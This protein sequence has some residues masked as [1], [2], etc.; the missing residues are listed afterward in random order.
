VQI[1]NA[2]AIAIEP[3]NFYDVVA[4]SSENEDVAGERLL[5]EYG[6]DPRAQT[7]ETSPHA[8]HA[9]RKSDPRSGA[10]LDHLR[11]LSRIER[12]SP[13]SAPLSTLIIARLGNSMWIEPNPAGCRWTTGSRISTSPGIATVTG[14]KAVVGATGPAN[15][16]L[17]KA[18]RH[19]NTWLAFTLFAG[20]TTNATLAPSSSVSST[21]RGFSATERNRRTRRP[22]FPA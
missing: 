2:Q 3:Q 10:K 6:L 21:I 4:A 19:V 12:N 13:G 7:V 18:R 20:A 8:R 17:L 22:A 14:S 16:A 11:R 1:Q 9:G 5:V 15:S